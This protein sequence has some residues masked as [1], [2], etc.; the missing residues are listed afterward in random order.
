MRYLCSGLS[1]F[2][3]IIFKYKVES[4]DV[5]I[6][7]D[8]QYYLKEEEYYLFKK[9]GD[10]VLEGRYGAEAIEWYHSLKKGDIP[11]VQEGEAKRGEIIFK[12]SKQLKEKICEWYQ[13]NKSRLKGLDTIG[14]AS[15][16]FAML[17]IFLSPSG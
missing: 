14:L 16:V 1:L 17:S 13:K 7:K 2:F 8:L 6:S 15:Q 12:S 3:K 9:F 4:Y 11:T 10:V 5:D